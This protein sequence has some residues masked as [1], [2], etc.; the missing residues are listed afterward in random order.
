MNPPVIVDTNILISALI[1]RHS[2]LRETLIGAAPFAHAPRF[3]FFELFKH[4]ERIQRSTEFTESEMLETL[5]TILSSLRFVDEAVVP[6][7]TWMEA[8]RLCS[9]VDDNDVPFVALTLHLN[10]K[11]WTDDEELVRGLLTKGFDHF[12]KL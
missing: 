6:L 3:V 7:G 12:F 8:R 10:G 9:G 4:K 2:T 5:G 1:T 11:L